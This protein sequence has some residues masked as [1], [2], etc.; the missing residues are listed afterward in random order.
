MPLGPGMPLDDARQSAQRWFPYWWSRE[1]VHFLDDLFDE[2][3][4]LPRDPHRAR[5]VRERAARAVLR[6][7]SA[8]TA[9]G[10]RRFGM[11]DETRAALRPD[12]RAAGSR[13]AGRRARG[14]SSPIAVP[15]A[16]GILTMPMFLEKYAS[17]RA[18]GAALYNAFLCKSFSPTTT[19]LTPSDRTEPDG[20]AGLLAPATRRSSRSRRTS[21]ASSPELR[22]PAAGAVS[23]A[24]T[25]TCKKDKN[26]TAERAR[27]TRSTTSRSPTTR[28]DAAERVR[29]ARARRRDAGRG[30]RRT[31]PQMPE[32]AAVRGARVTSSF[33]GRPTT[34]DDEAARSR[35]SRRTS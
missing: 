2:R 28:R 3:P 17:A 31:S 22:V 13:A 19:Q 23:R 25:P 16:A 12:E 11:L 8:G 34:P 18:R 6:T 15:H 35:R 29:L 24:H 5:D 20:A 33:L 27:A 30:R 32:F 10:P 14:R 21:R 7:S 9:A 26:G 4:R 1:A